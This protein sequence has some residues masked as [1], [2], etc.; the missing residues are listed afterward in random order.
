[1]P[2]FTNA[3][4]F[5][6]PAASLGASST[7]LPLYARNDLTQRRKRG[8]DGEQ[9]V[10]YVPATLKAV[11]A[12]YFPDWMG[13][14]ILL[15]KSSGHQREFSLTDI[16]IQHSYAEHERVPPGLL[17]FVS[18]GVPLIVLVPLGAL[19]ARNAWDM[20]NSIL[21]LFM[22]CLMTGVITQVI[23]MSVGRPRPDL[24][25]R[26]LPVKGAADHPV[27]GLSTVA[28][29]TNPDQF[30]LKDGFKSFPSGHSSLSFAGLGF[31]SLYLAGKM[32]LWDIR[33]HRTRAWA[34]LVPLLGG[35]MVAI[36]RT[37]DNRHHWQDIVIGS[38]LGVFISWVS[39]RTYY[40][41]LSHRQCHLPL[42][43]RADP[44]A[45]EDSMQD[46]DTEGDSVELLSGE[47]R[48]ETA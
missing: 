35:A 30:L 40:P 26:C 33:G 5:C 29:C 46:D 7:E 4:L 28:I 11:V 14:Q 6:F 9:P 10:D 20:H 18:V 38:L 21:G 32:H 13:M 2:A 42:A 41:Q 34:A 3:I 45:F 17:A 23:K 27:F 25:A 44:D 8:S 24:I 1:M 39:Y 12:S 16:S 22:S 47:R 36:S 19:V 31:L 43:P 48:N 37:R 15:N